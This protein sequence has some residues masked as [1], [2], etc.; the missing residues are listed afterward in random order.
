MSSPALFLLLCVC[1]FV[2]VFC[3]LACYRGW[4]VGDVRGFPYPVSENLTPNFKMEKV[5]ESICSSDK[6]QIFN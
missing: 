6:Y 5:S 4:E 1:L 2:I 3:L